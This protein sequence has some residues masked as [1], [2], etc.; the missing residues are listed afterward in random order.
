MARD[1]MQCN[2]RVPIGIKLRPVQGHDNL[3]PAPNDVGH[4]VGKSGPNVDALMAQQ[5]VDWLDSVFRDST[6][7]FG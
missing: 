5:P 1:P 7:R 4:P 3:R 2:G 6:L